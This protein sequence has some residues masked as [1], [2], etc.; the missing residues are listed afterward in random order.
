[1]SRPAVLRQPRDSSVG[2]WTLASA[3]RIQ[4]ARRPDRN[5]L[6]EQRIAA[7]AAVDRRGLLKNGPTPP[8]DRSRF[9]VGP[10]Q[11]H[12]SSRESEVSTRSPRLLQRGGPD[13]G[14]EGRR[15]QGVRTP[16]NNRPRTALSCMWSTS[17]PCE[18]VLARRTAGT[19]PLAVL[20]LLPSV[21][22]SLAF[23]PGPG[24]PYAMGRQP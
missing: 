9:G 11:G 4:S 24:Q 6:L 1:M 13:P 21:L 17:K 14:D 2:N 23:V 15:R 16:R 20:L 8:Y 5:E 12:G 7:F 10:G 22:H 18:A 19:R 3:Q